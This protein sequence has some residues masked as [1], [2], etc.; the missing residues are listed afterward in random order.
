MKVYWD[1]TA[2]IGLVGFSFDGFAIRR[3]KMT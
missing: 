3:Q 1:K 2:I